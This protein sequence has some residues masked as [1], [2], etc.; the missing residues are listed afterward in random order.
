MYRVLILGGSGFL[1]KAIITEMNKDQEFDIYGTYFNN[2]ISCHEDRSFKLVLN[3]PSNISDILNNVRPHIVISCLRGD[4]NY[5]LTIHIKIAE[6]LEKID[7]RLYFCSTANVFD[8]D[9]SRPHYE[10]DIP[11]SS[12]DYG[13]FK[14]EC[15]NRIIEILQDNA[16]ILRLPQIWGLDS[17][18]M[19][20]LLNSLSNN[21][22]IE[23]YPNLFL[24][25]NID[26][27]IARQLNYI[28]KH[29]LT[30]IFHLTAGDIISQKDFYRGLI[31]G[32]GYND[33]KMHDNF[34]EKGYFALLSTRINEFPEWLQITNKSIINYLI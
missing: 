20:A 6:Y 8:N 34:E 11:N 24:T 4:Y 32:L 9:L 25:T 31:L 26:V 21:E 28:I 22:N 30:G 13:R 23:V 19:N 3:D 2:P 1:G 33:A 27:M 15:E 29:G 5:Q 14:I 7:G 16:C 17:L 12:T 18:R 10:Y